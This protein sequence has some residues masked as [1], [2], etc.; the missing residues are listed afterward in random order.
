MGGLGRLGLGPGSGLG[1]LEGRPGAAGPGE[2]AGPRWGGG[3][4]PGWPAHSGG[5]GWRKPLPIPVG[6]A[7]AAVALGPP[8]ERG[9]REAGL[10][11]IRARE[12]WWTDPAAEVNN[13]VVSGRGES[14]PRS[15]MAG[16][17]P[18]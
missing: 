13:D 9:A 2:V 15:S 3:S 4:R 14:F 16:G 8:G 12:M 5:G 17:A 1:R 11:R 10:G 18:P 6:T 7:A